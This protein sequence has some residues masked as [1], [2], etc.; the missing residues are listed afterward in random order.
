MGY[1]LAT[2]LL[3]AVAA[4]SL[5]FA[6]QR[7]GFVAGLAGVAVSAAIKALKPNLKKLWA[8]K[9]PEEWRKLR[10]QRAREQRGDK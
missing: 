7:P 1:W 3:L 2:F 10:E 6:F 4:V 5:W 9:T 8:S